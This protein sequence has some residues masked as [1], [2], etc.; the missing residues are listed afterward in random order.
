MNA[1]NKIE[2]LLKKYSDNTFLRATIN[3]IPYI[4]G[5]L[6]AIMT[7]G[8]QQKREERYQYFLDE[9]KNQIEKLSEDKLDYNYLNSEEFYDLFVMTSS[10][11]VNTRIQDKVKAYTKILSSSLTHGFI[12][13][14]NPEDILNI[15]KIIKK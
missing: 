10:Y 3:G 4:G 13:K 5:A 12:N 2:P 14:T 7:T 8:L 9:L 15:I 11:V 1:K 6:D